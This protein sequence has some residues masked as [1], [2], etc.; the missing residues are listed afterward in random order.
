MK[1]RKLKKKNQKTKKPPSSNALKFQANNL[2]VCLSLQSWRWCLRCC[3][4][5]ISSK[6]KRKA[7]QNYTHTLTKTPP[8]VPSSNAIQFQ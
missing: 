7:E 8:S 4:V 2:G 1:N 6:G 3:S 5:V